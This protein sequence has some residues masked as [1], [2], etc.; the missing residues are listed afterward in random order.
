MRTQDQHG[1]VLADKDERGLPMSVTNPGLIYIN[2]VAVDRIV[3]LRHEVLRAGLPIMTARFEGDKDKHTLHFGLFLADEAGEPVGDPVGCASL[4][5]NM[6]NN[7]VPA[8]QLRGMA[9]ATAYQGRGLGKQLLQWIEKYLSG[10]FEY[11]RVE[12]MWCNARATAIGFYEQNGWQRVSD[13]FE[14]PTAGPHYKM[15]KDIN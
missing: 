3:P 6:Y 9:T 5:L 13:V 10:C 8:W 12:M 11:A 1:I 15:I 4:M 2:T 14:V 7:E